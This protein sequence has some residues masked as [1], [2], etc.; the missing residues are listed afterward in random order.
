V[1]SRLPEN[2]LDLD[3]LRVKPSERKTRLDEIIEICYKVDG[4]LP[5][6]EQNLYEGI[7][8]LIEPT[9]KLDE[10][11]NK[12]DS[13]TTRVLQEPGSGLDPQKK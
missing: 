7:V 8:K 6:N 11:C 10:M 1:D 9:T 2:E 13:R 4:R 3:E 5:E 12:A